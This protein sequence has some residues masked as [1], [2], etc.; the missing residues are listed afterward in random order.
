M[1]EKVFRECYR[2]LDFH[3]TTILPVQIPV[4]Y[5]SSFSRFFCAPYRLAMPREILPFERGLLAAVLDAVETA[6]RSGGGADPGVEAVE[7]QARNAPEQWFW[8]F[9]RHPLRVPAPATPPLANS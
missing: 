2:C 8:L 3:T 4:S 9:R 1:C 6:L 7:T 5:V